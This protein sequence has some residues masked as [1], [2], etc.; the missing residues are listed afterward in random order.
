[1]KRQIAGAVAGYL[2]MVVCIIASF[3]AAFPLLGMD[4]LFRPGTYEASTL[5]ITLSFVLGLGGAIVGGFVAAAVGRAPRAVHILAVLVLTFGV[6]SAVAAM[7][8]D[9]P[10]GGARGP[11]ATMATAMSNARQP[12]WVAL[13]NPLLGV[14]GVLIGGRRRSTQP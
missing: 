4:R 1:M 14:V 8:A 10:R 6:L 3:S 2:A 5:W 12:A 11:E 7:T 9:H 13:L